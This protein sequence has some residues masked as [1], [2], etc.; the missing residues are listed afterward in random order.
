MEAKIVDDVTRFFTLSSRVWRAR[1]GLRRA[2][3][4]LNTYG[5]YEDERM[6]EQALAEYVGARRARKEMV[7]ELT[8]QCR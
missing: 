6:Y 5:S 4:Q 8:G 2:K 7:C 1:L 3:R